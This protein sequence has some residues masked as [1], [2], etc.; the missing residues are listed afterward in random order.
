MRMALTRRNACSGRKKASLLYVILYVLSCAT[1]HSPDFTVLMVG[2]LLGGIATS[3]LFSAFESWIVAEHF[4]KGFE[5]RWLG[6]TFSKAVFV[7]NGLVA[8]LAGLL[9]NYLVDNL[10]LGPVAPFDASATVLLIGGAVILASW[11]ENYGDAK[12]DHPITMQFKMAAAAI[13]AGE[14][15]GTRGA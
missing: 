5:E 14:M 10:A 4:N 3:L 9:A 2:R 8:I 1:K 13:I 12:N 7:G 11:G 6:D 15:R